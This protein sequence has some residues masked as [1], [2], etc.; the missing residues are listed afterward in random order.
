MVKLSDGEEVCPFPRVIG[1]ENVKI[2]FN[3]LIGPLSLSIYLR[4]IC[5]GELDIIVEESC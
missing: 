1:T 2:C 4:M 3:F 5:S